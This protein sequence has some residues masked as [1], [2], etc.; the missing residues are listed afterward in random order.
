MNGLNSNE[1]D[2][3]TDVEIICLQA[4][5]SSFVEADEKF[6]LRELSFGNYQEDSVCIFKKDENWEVC[7]Y[8][9]GYF[10]Q[11]Q[12]FPNCIDSCKRVIERLSDS[13][14]LKRQLL[15]NFYCALSE[16]LFY[17]SNDK[18]KSLVR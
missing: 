1:I 12:V 5:E 17:Y 3:L 4:L 11:K 7:I 13:K 14:E 6:L 15:Y 10:H 8:E 9:K 16:K 2:N 18:G